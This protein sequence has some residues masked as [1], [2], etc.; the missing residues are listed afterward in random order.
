VR[1]KVAIVKLR[2]SPV[3]AGEVVEPFDVRRGELVASVRLAFGE[4]LIT[5]LL[6]V[7]GV[8]AVG[9]AA[10]AL[11]RAR[12]G[13][14]DALRSGLSQLVFPDGDTTSQILQMLSQTVVTVTA[15]VFSLLLVAVQQTASG[16]SSQVIDQFLRRRANQV[17][18]GYFLGVGVLSLLVAVSGHKEFNPVLS[19]AVT[20]VLAAVAVLLLLPLVY[21]TLNQMRPTVVV[22]A[23]HDAVVSARARQLERIVRRT[24]RR[25]ELGHL[26]GT[27]LRT[28]QTGFLMRLDIDAVAGA[29]ASAA[30][31]VEVE[32]RVTIGQF[33]AYH[34]KIAIIRAAPEVD[35]EPLA[36]VL[37]RG[38]HRER[39][40][41]IDDVDAGYGLEQL[42]DIA[43]TAVS[44]SKHTPLPG[45]LVIENLR[46]I[47]ARF[48]AEDET[49]E[50]AEPL[51]VVYPDATPRTLMAALESLA[52]VA[53]E[54][55]QHHIYAAL[56]EALAGMLPRLDG[57]YRDATHETIL[58]IL[59]LLRRHPPSL[60]LRRALDVAAAALEDAGCDGA[61]RLRAAASDFE[62]QVA[63]PAVAGCY[64]AGKSNGAS[65]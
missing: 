49:I 11:D 55:Q 53:T 2:T 12:L 57:W 1:V 50:A 65:S 48:S 59:P 42:H 23:V 38:V 56:L 31:E 32:L 46:D 52:V 61:E 29:I 5:A 35:I 54:A 33:V 20:L 51:P 63:T 60:Q 21:T 40:R 58:R 27:P 6:V 9:A 34:D 43:W 45:R 28:E 26:P 39:Q 22:E 18:F 16:L 8:I 44:S 37:E 4:F 7:V 24:R 47:L 25:P 10:Y 41:N 19:G 17:Y 36:E 3:E 13:V 64:A 30:G 15:I 62:R 14:L